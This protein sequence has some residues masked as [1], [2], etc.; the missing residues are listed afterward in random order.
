MCA[1]LIVLLVGLSHAQA[2][3]LLI[4]DIDDTIKNSHVLDKS[5]SISNAVK[6]EN[7]VLGM[8][9]VYHATQ[10]AQADI[11]FYYVSNAP[12]AI[13]HGSHS[14]FLSLNQFPAGFLRLRDG[15]F[16]QD[17]KVTEIRK[18]LKK[19]NPH[20]VIFVGD[21]GEKDISIYD[22]IKKEYP[23]IR[24]VTYIRLAYT[25]LNPEDTGTP[26]RAG[27]IGFA[28]SLDL[29]LQLHQQSLVTAADTLSFARTFI[30]VYAYE[31]EW[32]DSGTQAIPYWFDCRD[33][34]WTASDSDFGTT[35]GYINV[36]NRILHR[37]SIPALED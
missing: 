17:F 1:V 14:D 19:E 9:A 23:Q 12:K 22:Q 3:T 26:L 27:Q 13:M 6:T 37:C 30:N 10:R 32:N 7:L 35:V 21:N 28:T 29:M 11:R 24:F 36:K 4:S 31:D 2:K 16:Q 33:F 25:I 34:K 15:L 8:N 5:D 18:I 20:L